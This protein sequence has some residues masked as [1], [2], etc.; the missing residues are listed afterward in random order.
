MD[1]ILFLSHM[2]ANYN[3]FLS[4]FFFI[5]PFFVLVP[6]FYCISLLKFVLLPLP[7]RLCICH[8]HRVF[9]QFSYFLISS[10]I[11]IVARLAGPINSCLEVPNQYAYE[12]MIF[13]EFAATAL[14][15]FPNLLKRG[16]RLSVV[17]SSCHC[18][19][20]CQIKYAT[21]MYYY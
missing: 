2:L 18:I 19:F 6:R 1:G 17:A 7:I 8:C 20:P 14:T 9:L 16:L 15:T 21:A 11:A 4:F 5:V 10:R 12:L 3:P 13:F